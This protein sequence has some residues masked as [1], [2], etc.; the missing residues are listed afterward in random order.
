MNDKKAFD[1]EE[2]EVG[3]SSFGVCPLHSYKIAQMY[4]HY[5]CQI[6]KKDKWIR[7]T[8]SDMGPG[9][10]SPISCNFFHHSE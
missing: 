4:G 3:V 5:F 10:E 2:R 8:K 1:F 7:I 9:F 6:L